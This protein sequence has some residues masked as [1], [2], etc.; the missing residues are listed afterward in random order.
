MR[1]SIETYLLRFTFVS[2][3]KLC[4]SIFLPLIVLFFATPSFKIIKEHW[5]PILIQSQSPFIPHDYPDH[6]HA[7]KLA[8]RFF[9]AIIIGFLHLKVLG[10][11]IWQYLNGIFLF[12]VVGYVVEKKT[13]DKLTALYSILLTAFIFTGKVSFINFKDTFDSLILALLILCFT[14]NNRLIIY[15]ILLIVGF[16]DERGLI[17][18]GFLFLYYLFFSNYKTKNKFYLAVIIASWI[19]YFLIRFSLG[20]FLGLKTS[21]GGF[22]FKTM[23]LNLNFAPLSIWQTFEG[24][25][26][27]V[28][29][30]LKILYQKNR[31]SFLLIVSQFCLVLLV[32]FMVFDVTRSL[33]YAFP[34]IIIAILTLFKQLEIEKVNSYLFYSVIISFI[35]PVYSSAGNTNIWL[36]P[37][38]LKLLFEFFT[39]S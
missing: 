4:L 32:A 19:S 8:F 35:Y 39:N 33:V 3:W 16:T 10:I 29:L 5:D 34:L 12:Y 25:W 23:A 6:S 13:S 11:I 21:T 17:C 7:S 9:P 15:F 37:F 38:P 36:T 20:Y 28:I 22:D 30:F 24:G 27:L 14:I 18:S 26:L 1:N 2:N 31:L